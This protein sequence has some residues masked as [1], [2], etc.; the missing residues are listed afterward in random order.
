M[1]KFFADSCGAKADGSQMS[2]ECTD[3][4]KSYLLQKTSLRLQPATLCPVRSPWLL[5]QKKG[6][7]QQNLSGHVA[8]RCSL[9][10][11]S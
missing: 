10:G 4:S 1:P 5:K 8:K 11:C 9:T 2:E 6:H 3:S 7:L